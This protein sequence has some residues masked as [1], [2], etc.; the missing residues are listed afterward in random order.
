M[1]VRSRFRP[2]LALAALAAAL[3]VGLPDPGRADV[4]G[5]YLAAR[6]AARASDFRE[7]AGYFTKALVEDPSNTM[8]MEGAVISFVGAGNVESAIPIARRLSGMPGAEPSQ[9]AQLVMLASQIK[10]GAHDELLA[11]LAAGRRTSP[12]I[13]G[14]TAAWAEL[15]RGRMSEAV[16]AFRSLTDEGGM[17]IFGDY[18]LA[19][20]LASVGDFEGAEALFSADN[21]IYRNT[22]RGAFAHAQILSQ[23]ERPQDALAALD[24]AF[25]I[26]ADPDLA[27]LRL[28]LQAGEPVPFD[29]VRN[30]TDGQAE[31]FLTLAAALQGEANSQLVLMY[32]R[33]AEYLR[34][35]LA[36]AVLTSGGLL[37]VLGQQDLAIENYG[38]IAPGS[39]GYLAAQM[40]RAQA[41]FSSDRRDEA[42]A[43]MTALSDS[44]SGM[45]TVHIGLGDM[46][47][48]QERWLD[49]A[50]AYG[51]AIDLIPETNEGLW[52]IHF[53]RA[54]C[55]ER[56][57]QWDKAEPD[58]RKALELRPDQPSV[59]NYLGYSYLEM[60]RN[61]DEALG[62]IQRAVA[63]EPEAGHI[64]DSLAWGYYLIGRYDEALEPMERAS[65]MMPV[66][67]VVTDHMGDVYWAVGRKREARFQ[68]YRAL[69]FAPEEKDAARIRRK[70]EVG[71]DRVL[72]EEGAKP[73]AERGK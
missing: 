59:L 7:A 44:H 53:N 18:H 50:A 51:R 16:E 14:L 37:E 28:K 4:A 43:T 19:L 30:A 45:M 29:I 64:V 56:A 54:I 33:I 65:Q 31:V 70:L 41:L 58:F 3:A 17:Q 63:A 36:D 13:D 46:L 73:L 22:R 62:M 52:L 67:P 47:Q 11:D 71:L 21:A 34:P 72:A 66:D 5:P 24:E 2:A 1:T 9:P 69:S 12:L 42:I 35:D 61:L 25:Q 48:A 26:D 15:G 39:P 57:K 32:S 27:A 49:A 68:W 8:L 60:N 10:R 20:A 55:Y 23:L 38:R 6:T 40:G